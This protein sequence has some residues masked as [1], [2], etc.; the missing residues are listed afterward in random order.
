MSKYI[1]YSI[2]LQLYDLCTEF[3][4]YEQ[5]LI[6]H[7]KD[8]ISMCLLI[9]MKLIDNLK[10]QINYDKMKVYI[11]K[12]ISYEEFRE[13]IKGRTQKIKANINPEKFKSSD[14]LMQALKNE[15]KF[16][17]ISNFSLVK[18][19]CD[20][21]NLVNTSIKYSLHKDKIILIFNDNDK[22]SFYNNTT[23][24]IDKSLL[25]QDNQINKNLADNSKKEIIEIH[26][27]K[28]YSFKTDLEILIRLFY[29]Y[30]FFKEKDNLD[31]KPLK[32]ENN[33]SVYLINNDWIEKYKSFFEYKDLENYLLQ[34]KD[35]RSNL[36]DNDFIS[37]YYIR[38]L[39]TNLPE[40]YIILFIFLFYNNI[41]YHIYLLLFIFQEY[42]Y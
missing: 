25:V 30:R 22:L 5:Y 10:K 21:K 12:N 28:E 31:F 41:F 11:E 23:G 14:D 38:K 20:N 6:N 36:I 40:E 35:D 37:E 33:R 18:K 15:K 7:A 27:M 9:D 34:L 2:S 26:P 24:L 16:Y 17:I 4:K 42:L 19:I 8:Q 3:Y 39:I 29:Y 1:D 32:I 13:K